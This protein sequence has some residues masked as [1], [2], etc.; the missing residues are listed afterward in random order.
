ME[1]RNAILIG[2]ELPSDDTFEESLLELKNLA[3]SCDYKPV[4]VITQKADKPTPSFYI[5]RGKVDEIKGRI[6]SIAPDVLIFGQEL[7]PVHLRNLEEALDIKILDRTMLILEIFE[8]RAKSQVSKLQV[9]LAH[10]QYMLPRLIGKYQALSRQRG[11]TG[12]IGGPGEQA[13]ELDRRRLRDQILKNRRSL[14]KLV[15]Q[16]RQQRKLR[17][18][19]G[20]FTVAIV[21]YTNAGKSTLLNKMVDVSRLKPDE[22]K[23]VYQEDKLFA[24]LET[25]ARLI[26]LL[27]N[28][29]FVAIDTVGFVRNMPTHLIAAF[30]STLE[31]IAEADVLLVVFDGSDH[32]WKKHLDVVEEVLDEIGAG[33]I[34]GI[35]VRNKIDL[36]GSH[37]Q[38]QEFPTIDVSALSGAGIGPLLLGISYLMDDHYQKVVLSVPYESNY[39]IGSL[40]L[41]GTI[42][43]SDYGEQVITI[44]VEI[45][46]QL[47]WK[48]KD[49][50]VSVADQ[51]TYH[52]A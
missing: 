51:N 13:L 11:A 20:I 46:K 5:G 31:E 1:N 30:K 23:H 49:F 22:T 17:S 37:L 32:E 19:T 25:S 8:R 35:Y 28:R 14:A 48:Y 18:A 16:R 2:L 42:I 12:T 27:N 52:P 36:M 40:E 33:D 9:A 6:A 29:K 21:G 10:D 34:P 50:I 43:H 38:D 7:S 15:T 24:T 39:L 4:E 45:P 41:D 44:D 47:L 3:L 26:V